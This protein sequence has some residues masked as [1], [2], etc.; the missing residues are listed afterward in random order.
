M[1][2][3]VIIV[4]GGSSS[5]MCGMDK[6]LCAV[7]GVPVI[8]RSVRAF[9]GLPQ[10]GEII[11]VASE[12]RA[13]ET[14]RLLEIHGVSFPVVFAPC[15]GTRQQSAESGFRRSTLPLVAIHDAARPFVTAELITR[16]A[17]EAERHGAAIPAVAV[18]DTVKTVEGGFS[19]ETPDRSTLF[20]AQTPQIFKREIYE[21]ALKHSEN[22]TDDASMAER[23]GFPVKITEGDYRNIKITTPDDLLLVE[24][25]ARRYFQ[26]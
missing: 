23:G 10:V 14:A 26:G 15:G 19:R 18:K 9:A 2:I 25:L 1:K 12:E 17:E 24:A 3:S 5:R 13:A 16:I 20:A 6:L 21:A 22:A 8:V 11:V 4:A 7:D